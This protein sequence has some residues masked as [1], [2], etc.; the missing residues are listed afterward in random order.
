VP[1]VTLGTAANYALLAGSTIT[2]TGTSAICGS[3]GLSPGSSVTGAPVLSCGGISDVDDPASVTAKTDLSTAY[4]ELA[5]LTST[6]TITAGSDIGGETL[7]PGVYTDSGVL[8][9]GS[10]LILDAEGNPCAVFVFQIAGGLTVSTAGVQVTLAGGTNAANVY[11][12]VAGATALGASVNF[13]G[14]I[15]DL[16]SISM[17]ADAALNGR[18]L[19]ETGQIALSSNAITMP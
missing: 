4:T 14:N 7:F 8:N 18:A 11:W 9:I 16:T 19:A 10:N 13:V 15:L 3:L 5:A 12:Q 2:N 6:S 17:G 1:P